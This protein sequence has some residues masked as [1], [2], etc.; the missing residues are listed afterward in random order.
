MVKGLTDFAAKTPFQ[1]TGIGQAARQLLAANVAVEDLQGELQVLGD[2]AAGAQVPLSDMAQI[3]AKSMNKGKVQTEEINQLSERGIPIIDALV[4]LAA[5]Y[6]NTISKE[7]VYKA[8]EQGQITF[9]TLREAL[10]LLTAE[11][12]IFNVQM[13]KQS[14]TLFGLFSTLKDNVFLALA[15]VGNKLV[16]TF[17]VKENMQMFIAWIGGLVDRFKRLAEERPGLVKLGF[18]I[19]AAAAVAAPAL[20]AL[21]IAVGAVGIGLTGLAAA[22]GVIFGP[23]GLAV[24]AIAGAA[25]L[26]RRY[27]DDIIETFESAWQGIRDAFPGTAQFLEDLWSAVSKPAAG[28]FTWIEDAWSAT[29]A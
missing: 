24:A 17:E 22:F 5:K 21:G 23:I 8:A 10:G 20:I 1:L 6:G 14:Q 29:L 19:A 4:K 12:G 13:E 3:Y 18:A 27:W 25:Y 2:I 9:K 11:G 28:I 16:E 26:I 7:G 15:A